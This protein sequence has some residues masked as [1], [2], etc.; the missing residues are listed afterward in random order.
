[1]VTAGALGKIVEAG[2]VAAGGAEPQA[3]AKATAITW[4]RRPRIGDPLGDAVACSQHGPPRVTR[5]SLY[6][7]RTPRVNRD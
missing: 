4:M 1:V 5:R 6:A 2:A 3:A 7:H